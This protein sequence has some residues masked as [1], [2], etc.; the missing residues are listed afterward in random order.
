M[1]GL[2][3]RLPA[4]PSLEQLRKQAREHL[5]RLR[6]TDAEARLSDA[7]HAL[8]AEYGFT[9]W[10][11]LAEG[12]AQP[13]DESPDSRLGLSA[14]PPFY[15]IDT[16][17]NTIEPHAPLSPR[18][19]DTI[20]A[21]MRERAITGIATAAMTDDA[22]AKLSKLDFVTSIDLGG[23]RVLSDDGLQHLANMSQLERLELGGWHSPLTDCGRRRSHELR[24][25][26]R[27]SAVGRS[28]HGPRHRQNGRS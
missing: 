10:A 25:R 5:D 7:Q 8:A 27:Q 14:A 16:E 21:L 24:R 15:R 19:W 23:A 9:S 17:R 13:P 22:L 6:E 26:N 18:D 12:L 11:A 4:R 20:F 3:R 28:G 2:A 1:S